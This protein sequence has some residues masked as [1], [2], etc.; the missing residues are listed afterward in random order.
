MSELITT[1]LNQS[2]KKSFY[3]F[4]RHYR[5]EI[6]VMIPVTS[7]WKD[8]DNAWSNKF[9]ITGAGKLGEDLSRKVKVTS[10]RSPHLPRRTTGYDTLGNQ[11][12]I[13]LLRRPSFVVGK[14][15]LI[16][17]EESV[18]QE[19]VRYAKNFEEYWTDAINE[20]KIKEDILVYEAEEARIQDELS[21]L[22]HKLSEIQEKVKMQNSSNREM[23]E[24]SVNEDPA[25]LKSKFEALERKN[26]MDTANLTVENIKLKPGSCQNL[27]E[28]YFAEGDG[29]TDKSISYI[30]NQCSKLRCL[31]IAYSGVE[32]E[33]S[34]MMIQ[35]RL[36]IEYL[37]FANLMGPR[38][39]N[40]ILAIIRSSPNLK[41]FDI[42]GNNIAIKQLNPNIHIDNFNE[43]Y[44]DWPDSET[45]S[46]NSDSE[47]E[48]PH[49]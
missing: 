20:C 33:D 42:S 47:D 18:N 30:I 15:L 32:I 16:L 48:L 24:D 21:R 26:K 8:L 17:E 43:E 35:K 44:C 25:G 12:P 13:S 3:Y 41:H 37:D 46:S 36:N 45:D 11:P 2:G 5:D 38:N 19:R 10:S 40:L 22:R 39:D 7:R 1:Y 4:L 34:S 28:L 27:E 29:I 14:G 6:I 49:L 31:D 23:D 9:I